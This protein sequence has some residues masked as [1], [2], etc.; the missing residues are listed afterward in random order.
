MSAVRQPVLDTSAGPAIV[1]ASQLAQLRAARDI[2]TILHPSEFT[3]M[4]PPYFEF[5]K[6]RTNGGLTGE[7]LVQGSL[8]LLRRQLDALPESNPFE[9][10]KP[11]FAAA[12]ASLP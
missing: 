2:I 11:R 4:L 1:S 6:R 8:N 3:E 9:K 7:A 5:V 10:F 12:R